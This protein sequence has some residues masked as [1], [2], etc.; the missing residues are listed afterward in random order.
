[1][2]SLTLTSHVG[3]AATACASTDRSRT[4]CDCRA[5]IAQEKGIWNQCATSWWQEDPLVFDEAAQRLGFH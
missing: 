4:S 3:N 5:P 2:A 1:M